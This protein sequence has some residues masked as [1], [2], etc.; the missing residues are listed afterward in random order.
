MK[1]LFNPANVDYIEKKLT[2][3]HSCDQSMVFKSN[4][5]IPPASDVSMG[6]YFPRIIMI[7]RLQY[8]SSQ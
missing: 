5:F 7:N 1:T 2:S 6:A 8:V 4:K 3:K